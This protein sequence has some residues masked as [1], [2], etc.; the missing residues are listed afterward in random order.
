MK[1]LRGNGP[2]LPHSLPPRL[3]PTLLYHSH[4]HAQLGI[5]FGFCLASEYGTRG[6]VNVWEAL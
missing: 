2:D 3:H 1:I 4:T 5:Y 6:L